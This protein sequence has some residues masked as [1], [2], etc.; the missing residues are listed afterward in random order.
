MVFRFLPAATLALITALSGIG[1]SALAQQNAGSYL[2]A[3]QARANNDFAASA[4][5]FM[6][7]LTR[8]PANPVILENAI[9][10]HLH[11]GDVEGALPMA[12]GIEDQKLVSQVS[13]MVLM[14]NDVTSNDFDSLLA[15]LEADRGLG[16]L[17]DDLLKAW[18]QLGQGD[19]RAALNSFDAVAKDDDLR[20][21]AIYHKALAL[22]SV[23][24]FE[25]ADGL[26]SGKTDGDIQA[27]RRGT[28]AWVTVL[29]QLE[30]NQDALELIEKTFG[31]SRD[32][33][34]SDLRSRLE[35]GERVPFTL[36]NSACEGV[37]EVFFSLGR[38]ILAESNERY[39]L[40][41]ARIAE[42]LNPSNIDA[43]LMTADLLGALEQFDLATQAY[44]S[45]PRDHPAYSS[46]ELGRADSLRRADK[47]DAA[48]EVLSQLTQTNPDLPVGHVSLGD[49]LRQLERFNEA[50]TAYDRALDLYP[51]GAPDRWFVHYVRAIS[52]ERL[53]HWQKAETDF[54]RALELNPGHPQVLNY[55]GYSLVE[56][57]V[58]L[59]EALDMIQQA[60][61]ARPDEGYI[62]DS[63]GWAL[64]RLG[65]YDEAIGHM[66]RAAELMPVDPVVNDHLGDVLWAVGRFTEAEFQWRRALSFVDP[67]SPLAGCRAGPHSPQAGRGP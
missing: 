49:L 39:T 29:S 21:F 25:A 19:M 3:R 8:D 6:Q 26:F 35:A 40:F 36:V 55:L 14:A 63:M 41:Y 54:R 60:V 45:V 58:K 27:T 56:Q 52:H 32:P 46:A 11:L 33:E 34:I 37:A 48:V 13:S 51:E 38:A 7:A 53:D 50:V 67:E 2:A 42:H 64:Y 15:R 43:V 66:E 18:A 31:A 28:L 20:S 47:S 22:A 4:Q 23:G 17:A 57:Q 65:R 10:A 12:Q 61:T 5:Y 9:A 16:N 30:R 62:V 59:D 1:Q 24:D 44:Q